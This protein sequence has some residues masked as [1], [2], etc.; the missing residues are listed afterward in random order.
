MPN[1]Q[2]HRGPHPEDLRLFDRTQLKRLRPAAEEIVWLLGRGYPLMTAVEW[3]GNHHQLEARQRLALQRALCSQ[4][5]R[6]RRDARAIERLDAPVSNSGRLRAR[7]EDWA[8]RW[9]FPINAAVVPN[10]D[11][12]LARGDNA[13]TSDSVVLDRCGSWLNLGRF[14]V[15]RHVP[16]AW[17]SGMFTLPSRVVD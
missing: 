6:T 7:I 2:R 17:R 4:E 1:R 9:T 10:P 5:Q 16:S 3:V 13:V 12:I 8:H 14:I 11:A 15:D